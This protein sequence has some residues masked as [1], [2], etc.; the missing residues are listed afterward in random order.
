MNKLFAMGFVILMSLGYSQS[1]WDSGIVSFDY[2]FP[3]PNVNSNLSGNILFGAIPDQGVGGFEYADAD[4]NILTLLAYDM[5][6]SESDTLADVLV[7]YMSDTTSFEPGIYDVNAATD[8]LKLFVWLRE[9]D[10]SILVGLIDSSFALEDLSVLNPFVSVTGNMEILE[11]NQAQLQLNFSGTMFNT[12][13]QPMLISGSFEIQNTLP[14]TVYPFG[15][16][17]YVEGAETGSVQGP[18]NPILNSEGVGAFST[19]IEGTVLYNLLAYHEVET[20]IYDIYGVALLGTA[21]NFPQ[22]EFEAEFVVSATGQTFPAAI[23]YAIGQV[24]LDD[25]ILLIASG[26]V[27]SIETF[28][29]LRLPG[30][31]GSVLFSQTIS[32]V[33]ILSFENLLM[34]NSLGET[35]M[36]SESWLLSDGSIDDVKG[37]A[38]HQAPNTSVLGAPF[39]NPFNSSVL[40]PL[41]LDRSESVTLILFNLR[42]QQVHTIDFGQV[43]PGGQNLRVDLENTLLDGGLYSFSIQ[44]TANQIGTGSFIYLK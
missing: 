20:S 36:L 5:Y 1:V 24:S 38:I 18:L 26:E 41:S 42:G 35:S 40:I 4:V 37:F 31:D 7:I 39:P 22:N 27:P 10:P 25:L 21:L 30:S 8:A 15:S 9:I 43:Q 32:G 28:P 19:T 33:A 12:S 44:S 17:E 11:I 13:F 3:V 23:P 14:V 16:L 6:V 34:A 29:Q 2:G